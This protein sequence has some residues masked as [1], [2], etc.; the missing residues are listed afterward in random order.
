MLFDRF[1]YKLKIK[2][3]KIC[4]PNILKRI[5]EYNH[6]V[7]NSGYSNS[8][9]SNS[10]W[11]AHGNN[12]P[13]LEF[14]FS[15]KDQKRLYNFFCKKYKKNPFVSNCWFN[16]YNPNSGSEHPIHDHGNCGLVMIYYVELKNQK[17]RTFLQ[18]PKNNKQ[19]IPSCK[20]GDVLI[21]PSNVL[22]GSPR[23]VY[24]SRKTI[25]SFNISLFDDAI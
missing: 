23:N 22:H 13:W 24:D 6:P 8:S 20:E 17:L 19:I 7:E 10:D 15:L 9:I 18:N 3:H 25:I 16:Q 11:N 4:K 5:S 2:D 1:Y 21:F 12:F 14:C